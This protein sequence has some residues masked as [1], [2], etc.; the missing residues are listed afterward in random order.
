M[1]GTAIHDSKNYTVACI[2][3]HHD[4]DEDEQHCD[5]IT[6]K[7][8]L[9]ELRLL[10]IKPDKDRAIGDLKD[11]GK[12]SALT[13]DDIGN[14]AYEYCSMSRACAGQGLRIAVSNL[15]QLTSLELDS[16]EMYDVEQR[17]FR[18]LHPW[19]QLR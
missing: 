19:T 4:Y 18:L 17:S 3:A 10:S 1:A 6:E 14:M 12:C 15:P 8:I 13:D 7:W 2:G 11:A 9:Q 16:V 5:C